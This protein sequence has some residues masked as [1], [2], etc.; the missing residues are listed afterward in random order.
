[1]DHIT[2]LGWKAFPMAMQPS[3]ITLRDETLT[4]QVHFLNA[5]STVD[6]SCNCRT[7]IGSNGMTW[8]EPMGRSRTIEESRKLYNN[9]ANHWAPFSRE[10]EAKW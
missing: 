2:L 4:H 1:M 9:P 7:M 6:V 5:N 3:H 10:D 8:Y